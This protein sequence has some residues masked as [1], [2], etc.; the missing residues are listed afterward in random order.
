MT[1]EELRIKF[2]ENI[3][4]L[5]KNIPPD[6]IYIFAEQTFMAAMYFLLQWNDS[7]NVGE[8]CETDE[9]AKKWVTN[10]LAFKQCR[11]DKIDIRLDLNLNSVED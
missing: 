2:E 10:I 6:D 5:R 9:I 8:F 11:D 4:Y 1:K 3:E 7:I